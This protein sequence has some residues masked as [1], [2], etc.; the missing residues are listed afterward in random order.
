[1]IMKLEYDRDM[2]SYEEISKNLHRNYE[3]TIVVSNHD[4]SLKSQVP[5]H[6]KF[7]EV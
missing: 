1:M 7:S 3:R 5:S 6:G 4:R 2:P